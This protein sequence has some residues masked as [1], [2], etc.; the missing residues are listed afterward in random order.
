MA[1]LRMA[2]SV[3]TSGRSAAVMPRPSRTE[4][5]SSWASASIQWWGS[6]LRTAYSRS[7]M[8]AGVYSD[9]TIW[10]VS[11]ADDSRAVRRA[12][13][14]SSTVSLRRTSVS[15]FDRKTSAGTTTTSPAS[16]TLVDRYGRWRVTRLISPRKRRAPCRVISCS[17]GPRISTEP[18]RMTIQS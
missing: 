11:A 15:T 6:R 5:T 7:A 17:F 3:I 8:D 13:N 2:R 18:L 1:R 9:P 16:A 12:R 4:A 10:S 14:A